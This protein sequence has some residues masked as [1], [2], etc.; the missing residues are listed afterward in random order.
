MYILKA[1]CLANIAIAAVKSLSV[2]S[3]ND[4]SM[5]T[6]DPPSFAS[7]SLEEIRLPE[8]FTICS[9]SQQDR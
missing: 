5:F 7:V 9:S 4:S 3:F 1:A 8:N 2:F 6:S